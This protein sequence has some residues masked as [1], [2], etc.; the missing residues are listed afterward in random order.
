[1]RKKKRA[2]KKERIPS[3]S[4]KTIEGINKVYAGK[5]AKAGVK[6]TGILLRHS[7]TPEDRGRLAKK[8]GVSKK[9]V[10]EWAN[11]SDLLRIKGVGEE[12]SDMLEEI[13]V[14]TVKEL[15]MRNISNLYPAIKNYCD[16]SR[17]VRK[18]P[19]QKQVANWI[20]QSKMMKPMLKY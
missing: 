14:D 9:L 13:G 11:I 18:P 3:Y 16:K 8:V 10:L 5:L 6:T 19:S 20:K 15:K 2:T 7:I 4:I 12:Y 1:M 17:L